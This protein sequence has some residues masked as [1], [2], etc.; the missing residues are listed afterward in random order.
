MS[1]CHAQTKTKMIL[2][3]CY[4]NMTYLSV[5]LILLLQA[6]IIHHLQ[7]I[8]SNNDFVDIIFKSRGLHIVNLNV[9]HLV[10][11]LDELSFML[12]NEKGPDIFGACETFL[13][14]NVSDGQIAKNG[15]EFLRKDRCV[16]VD[17]N[18]GGVILYFRNI[19]T[20]KRRNELEVSKLETLWAEVV[21]P[22]AKPFLLCTLYR[23]QTQMLT[24]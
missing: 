2:R 8:T 18:G 10:P 7:T 4:Q 19:L 16:T 24:G 15:F 22:N 3:L 14:V 17:K 6:V 20:C 11:K 13:D 23:P 12:V 9:R 21:L 1:R 5:L